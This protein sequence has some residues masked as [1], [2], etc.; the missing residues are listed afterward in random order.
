MMLLWQPIS[1]GAVFCAATLFMLNSAVYQFFH[2]KRGL[3]FAAQ[4]VV[5]HWFYY[6]YSGLAFVLGTLAYWSNRQRIP[7]VEPQAMSPMAVPR[8]ALA[9]SAS[10]NA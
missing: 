10:T 9:L 2:Q 4:T 7:P 6:A 8:S 3:R 5:W 1:L